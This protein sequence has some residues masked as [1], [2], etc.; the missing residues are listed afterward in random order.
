MLARDIGDV[1]DIGPVPTLFL[2]DRDARLAGAYDGAPPTLHAAVESRVALL[3][4][5]P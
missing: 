5:R 2:F 3:A 1:G 4:R